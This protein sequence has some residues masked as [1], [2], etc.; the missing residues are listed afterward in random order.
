MSRTAYPSSLSLKGRGTAAQ[1]Q[2]EGV[3]GRGKTPEHLLKLAREARQEMTE[4]E[5][6]L[7]ERLRAHRMNGHKFRRQN[8]IGGAR[9]DFVC[10]RARLIVEVDGSQHVE[11][12]RSGQL[13][14]LF[15]EREG[16]RVVRVWNNDVLAR[17]DA[18]LEAILAAFPD[19][20]PARLTPGCP[21]PLR[22]ERERHF[23]SQRV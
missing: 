7:R 15:L 14:M 5:E 22:G 9:S 19:P 13:Q 17:L 1:R 18:V 6:M 2:G 3:G 16:Y 12:T 21:S 8:P 20:L 4:A 11:Q 23:V 10:P